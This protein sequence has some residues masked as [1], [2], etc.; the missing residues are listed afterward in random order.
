MC[1]C[2]VVLLP[3]HPQFTEV[4]PKSDPSLPGA[5]NPSGSTKHLVLL[6]LPSNLFQLWVCA[7][8]LKPK[9]TDHRLKNSRKSWRC[10]Q[11]RGTQPQH[12]LNLPGN[13]CSPK[14]KS[15][16]N[17][18][19]LLI[20]GPLSSHCLIPQ[21][22]LGDLHWPLGWAWGGHRTRSEKI[23]L[24]SQAL[25]ICLLSKMLNFFGLQILGKIRVL[26]KIYVNIF[27][28]LLFHDW[29]VSTL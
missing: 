5:V 1:P 22:T 15:L 2:S 16:R 21:T 11:D 12:G 8:A 7:K 26:D 27:L 13:I 28:A 19:P 29:S 24:P 17:G 14:A 10:G 20:S 6:W 23:W 9:I 18:I 4:P 25:I 3:F